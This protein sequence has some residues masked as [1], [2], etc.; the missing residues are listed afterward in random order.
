MDGDLK[1]IIGALMRVLDGD[2]ISREEV[3][4]LA[5]EAVGELQ[6]ALNEA[7]IKLLEFAY[8]CD[9]GLLDQRLGDEMRAALQESL[10]EIVR[11]SDPPFAEEHEA[12]DSEG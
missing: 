5:F 10:N 9:T 2:K 4:D 8:D 11:C 7:Y 12:S 3:E 6:V 1:E